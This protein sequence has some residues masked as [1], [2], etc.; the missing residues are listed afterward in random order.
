MS[1]LQPGTLVDDAY[2]NERISL[3]FEKMD[4]DAPTEADVSSAL[5]VTA[6]HSFS[7]EDP[8]PDRS[9]SAG[10]FIVGLKEKYLVSF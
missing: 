7:E 9:L 8:I 4:L 3:E 5:D 2:D 1:R 10:K 6:E